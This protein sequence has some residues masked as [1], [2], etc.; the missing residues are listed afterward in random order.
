MGNAVL[1][2]CVW[3]KIICLMQQISIMCFLIT[4]TLQFKISIQY[5]IINDNVY[6]PKGEVHA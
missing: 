2:Y 1:N 4:V 5:I 3:N 6:I